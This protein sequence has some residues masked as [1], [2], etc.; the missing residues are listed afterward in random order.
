MNPPGSQRGDW[1]LVEVQK[2]KIIMIIRF[3]LFPFV[4]F[5]WGCG[6]HPERQ[7]DLEVTQ[8]EAVLQKQGREKDE[9]AYR[10]TDYA[11]SLLASGSQVLAGYYLQRAIIHDPTSAEAWYQLARLSFQQQKLRQAERFA[12]RTIRY[13]EDDLLLRIKAWRMIEQSRRSSGNASGSHYAA[14]RADELESQQFFLKN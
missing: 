2:R 9:I 4:V 7:M 3:L 14:N 8:F 11:K 10:M 12:L 6:S 5:L 13:S 1:S